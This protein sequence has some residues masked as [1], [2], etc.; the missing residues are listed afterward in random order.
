MNPFE[1]YIIMI[2]IPPTMFLISQCM[3]EIYLVCTCIDQFLKHCTFSNR[4]LSILAL[5]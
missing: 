4:L 5:I 2:I 3:H 1:T